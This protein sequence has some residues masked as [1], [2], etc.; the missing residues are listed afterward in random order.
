LL[1]SD[2]QI[3][4]SNFIQIEKPKFRIWKKFEH[5]ILKRNNKKEKKKGNKMNILQ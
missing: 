5:Y 4:I 1:T 3:Q 2:T